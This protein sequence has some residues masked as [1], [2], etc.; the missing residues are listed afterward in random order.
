MKKKEN[1]ERTIPCHGAIFD[2]L[3]H[4]DVPTPT[5][6]IFLRA[7][8]KILPVIKRLSYE[9]SYTFKGNDR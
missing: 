1:L 5:R 8:L 9:L 4:L 2:A 7:H 6:N 3:Q